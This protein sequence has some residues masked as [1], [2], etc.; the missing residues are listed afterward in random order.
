MLPNRH[1]AARWWD[2]LPPRI[3]E[4]CSST[5]PISGE[6]QPDAP[7]PLADTGWLTEAGRI[8]LLFLFVAFTNVVVLLLAIAYCTDVGPPVL[9]EN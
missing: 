1:D 3:R 4:R 9:S 5:A 8:V 6:E 7:A 2:D